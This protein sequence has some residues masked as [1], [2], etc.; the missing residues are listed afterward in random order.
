MQCSIDEADK[1]T[2]RGKKGDKKKD[3]REGPSTPAPNP[4]KQKIK[5]ATHSTPKKR[6]LKKMPLKPKVSSTSDYDYV[7]SDQPATKSS[8]SEDSQSEGSP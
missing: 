3:V 8:E 6:K 2:K 4:K 5:G 1:P 7:P